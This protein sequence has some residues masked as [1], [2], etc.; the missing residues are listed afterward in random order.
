MNFISQ[1]HKF[2]SI[3]W[4]NIFTQLHILSYGTGTDGMGTVSCG[5]QRIGKVSYGQN[6]KIK[7]RRI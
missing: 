7:N 1:K 5:G 2:K 6:K 3:L 4:Y